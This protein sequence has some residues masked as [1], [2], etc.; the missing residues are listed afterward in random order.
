MSL[1][2]IKII[3]KSPCLTLMHDSDLKTGIL[4]FQSNFFSI[5]RH[6]FFLKFN[7]FNIELILRPKV[8]VFVTPSKWC[9]VQETCVRTGSD[10]MSMT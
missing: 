6:H 1:I 2:Y 10:S 8:T 3:L 7:I 9:L 5:C 4:K